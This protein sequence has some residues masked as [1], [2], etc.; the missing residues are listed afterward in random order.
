MPA[1]A[2]MTGM[3]WRDKSLAENIA[4]DEADIGGEFFASGIDWGG[5]IL[6]EPVSAGSGCQ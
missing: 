1:F 3:G 2:G 4:V 6:F 5:V